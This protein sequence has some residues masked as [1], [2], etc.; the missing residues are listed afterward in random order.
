MTLGDKTGG[1]QMSHCSTWT[2]RGQESFLFQNANTKEL[3][4]RKYAEDYR[5]AKTAFEGI[6]G[7]DGVTAAEKPFQLSC[8]RE[9][10]R[11]AEVRF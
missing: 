1:F 5:A 10:Y 7:M 6:A 4:E 2:M 8:S 11:E 3:T 9:R